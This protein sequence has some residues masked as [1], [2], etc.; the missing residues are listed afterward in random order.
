MCDFPLSVKS[1]SSFPQPDERSLTIT[2]DRGHATKINVQRTWGA[3]RK[4]R[5]LCRRA[6]ESPGQ[7]DGD[8][9][10]VTNYREPEHNFYVASSLPD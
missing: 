10:I 1:C 5:V 2:I 8:P 6:L 9:A 4:S 3:Y 7:S